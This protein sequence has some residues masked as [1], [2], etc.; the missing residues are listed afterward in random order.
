MMFWL[1]AF[2]GASSY[3]IAWL[4]ILEPAGINKYV[5]LLFCAL[6]V[7]VATRVLFRLRTAQWAYGDERVWIPYY[8]VIL[9]LV[10]ATLLT[11]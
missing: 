11:T 2:I 5:A 1:F 4:F 9:G 7:Y 6:L 10:A 8:L 3:I